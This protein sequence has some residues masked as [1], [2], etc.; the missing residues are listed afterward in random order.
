[1]AIG[2]AYVGNA[3]THPALYL[4]MFDARRQLEDDAEADTTFHVL[5]AAV[6]WARAEGRFAASTSSEGAALQLWA[7][8]HGMVMLVLTGALGREVLAAHLPA[9]ATAAFVGFGDEADAAG[10]SAA[11][12]WR[13]SD[14]PEAQP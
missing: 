14:R 13:S 3:L 1:M 11:A 2:S 5:V 9:M 4:T 10:A 6:E 12:G 7:L 8:T